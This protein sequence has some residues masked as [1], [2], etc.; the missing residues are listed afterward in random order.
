MVVGMIAYADS[1]KT[2]SR[3]VCNLWKDGTGAAFIPNA[4]TPVNDDVAFFYGV[5]PNQLDL[6]NAVRASG[7]DW[8]YCDNAYAPCPMIKPN[9]GRMELF[10]MTMNA[11]QC[12]GI[13]EGDPTRRDIYMPPIEPWRR[14]GS[15]VLVCVQSEWHHTVWAD[16][17]RSVW[18]RRTLKMLKKHTDRPVIVRDKPL[19]KPGTIAFDQALRNAWAVVTYNSRVA[20][21]A[22]LAG[23]PAFVSVP[24][25]ASPM[26]GA[27]LAQIEN[28]L[29]L[30]GREE[31]AAVLAANQWT[32]TEI[33]AG[34]A[35]RQLRGLR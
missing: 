23:V 12:T 14:G 4:P 17:P 19:R 24:C 27:D 3:R 13:G 35:W 6:F 16:E 11:A 22:I 10:R 31:W 26:A 7:Q 5:T 30:D 1:G 29:R 9:G 32:V 20:I 8:V 28:P 21:E 15:D 25:A 2:K 18:L 33:L 34:I